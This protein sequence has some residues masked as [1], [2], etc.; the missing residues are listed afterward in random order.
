[1]REEPDLVFEKC[2]TTRFRMEVH[3]SM[4]KT[5]YDKNAPSSYATRRNSS[6]KATRVAN[7][8]LV[9]S[10]LFLFCEYE[11]ST[12]WHDDIFY[13]IISFSK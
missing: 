2:E 6:C 3:R 5:L 1:M 4:A 10:L 11:Y 9:V 12:Q 7:K 13:F 8:V